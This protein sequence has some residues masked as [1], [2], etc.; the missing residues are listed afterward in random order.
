M[1]IDKAIS[2]RRSIREYSSKKIPRPKLIQI[3]KAGC[4]A[5]SLHNLQPWHM[6]V[7]SQEYRKRLADIMRKRAQKEVIFLNSLL[8][9]N[10]STIENAPA[11]IAVYNSRP[12][13]FRFKR[14]GRYYEKRCLTWEMQ[15]IS[16]CIENM[17]L[18][19]ASMQIG[20]AFI[21]C[22]LL[23]DSQVNRL[24][25]QDGELMMILTLGYP[26][27]RV[28]PLKRKP[29]NEVIDFV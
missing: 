25:K 19:A 14:I 4:K 13:S 11:A 26:K 2:S 20:T 29:I 6:V 15:S 23:C 10:A 21:G 8:R 12:L 28:K 17:M 16:C 22:V 27:T 5:P 3:I 1:D 9:D 18:K 7:L 24:L